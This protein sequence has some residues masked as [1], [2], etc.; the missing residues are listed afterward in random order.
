MVYYLS[1]AKMRMQWIDMW[2]VVH[3]HCPERQLKLK[4][5]GACTTVSHSLARP[6]MLPAGSGQ[7]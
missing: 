1:T 7:K 5:D 6:S 3:M 4:A 2:T